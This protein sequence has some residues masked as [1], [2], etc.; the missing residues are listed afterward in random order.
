M[1]V[2]VQYWMGDEPR[3]LALARLLAT[4]ERGDA[5]RADAH[6]VLARRVDCPVSP[7]AERTVDRARRAFGSVHL[8]RSARPETGHPDGCFGL[9]AGAAEGLYQ[10]LVNGVLPWTTARHAFFCEADGVPLRVDWLNRLIEAHDLTLAQNRR[11]TGA[12]MDWPYPHVNGNMIMDLQVFADYPSLRECPPGVAW[13]LHHGPI[14]LREA[15]ASHVIR[16]DCGSRDWTPGTL[17]CVAT[18][19]AWHHGCKDDTVLQFA[20]RLLDEE[21]P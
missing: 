3:A 14:L 11:V 5:P 7:E 12:V 21:A 10:M 20:R 1:I 16:N 15:R 9:W 2:V 19:S 6:L 18:Q 17:R 8:L 13:D 4:L